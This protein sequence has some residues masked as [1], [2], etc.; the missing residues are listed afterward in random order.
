VPRWKWGLQRSPTPAS[1]RIQLAIWTGRSF[2]L[3]KDVDR[4]G[5]VAR[6]AVVTRW[7]EDVLARGDTTLARKAGAAGRID[8][9]HLDDARPRA[10]CSPHPQGSFDFLLVLGLNSRASVEP[11]FTPGQSHQIGRGFSLR[12]AVAVIMGTWSRV[13]R[14]YSHGQSGRRI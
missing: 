8:D 3:L 5:G 7:Q 13:N 2:A 4:D 14:F 9:F 11:N 12:W 6:K 1:L 10:V